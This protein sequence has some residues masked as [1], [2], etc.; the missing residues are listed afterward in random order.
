MSSSDSHPPCLQSQFKA[1]E[2]A[3]EFPHF[4][5]DALDRNHALYIII[6]HLNALGLR[7]WVPR[8][9]SWLAQY[10][11]LELYA[12]EEEDQHVCMRQ[13]LL[14]H[15]TRIGSPPNESAEQT[16]CKIVE[17]IMRLE[18][19]RYRAHWGKDLVADAHSR[20]WNPLEQ[21]WFNFLQDGNPDDPREGLHIWIMGTL[22]RTKQEELR[23][24]LLH[25]AD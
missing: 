15:R 24:F 1:H 22:P 13:L 23:A 14:R 3:P 9:T 6:E 19:V 10:D 20:L 5:R 25:S 12:E 2:P 4:G 18:F 7:D 8:L 17:D 11:G 16:R 21:S